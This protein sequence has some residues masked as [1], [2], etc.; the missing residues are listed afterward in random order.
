MFSECEGVAAWTWWKHAEAAHNQEAKKEINEVLGHDIPFDTPKP[1]R[2]IKRILQIATS[3]G[4]L[5]LGSFAGSGTTG[6]VVL[7]MNATD[8]RLGLRPDHGPADILSAEREEAGQDARADADGPEAHPPGH[9]FIVVER[10][11]AIAKRHVVLKMN[12]TDRRLGLWPD[13]GPADI[14]SAEREEA[15]QDARA[16]ADGPEAH[17]PGHRFILV[18]REPAIAKRHAVLK[19]NATDRRLGLWPDHGPADILSAEREEP[20]Q[21]ARADADGPEAHP[22]GH[23][24]IV[25]EREPA[26][27]KPTG[28]RPILQATA[29]SWWR[30]SLLSPSRRARGPSSRPPPAF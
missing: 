5:V 28:Q 14:L 12:A 8:R 3:P 26:I 18:E 25:V 15:G 6:H 30:G 4:D 9:P 22:P 23:C 24:F 7:K 19:M 29:S 17:P 16:D 21:D 27:A 1:T 2:L 20:G 10:E 13:H 11:P